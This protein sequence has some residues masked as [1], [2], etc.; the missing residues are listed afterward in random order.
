[1]WQC[2]WKPE[3]VVLV[4]RF[5]DC[6]CRQQG[7]WPELLQSLLSA[8]ISPGETGITDGQALL[9]SV[10]L[11][12]CFCFVFFR[13]RV[14]LY[15]PGC[16]GTHSVDQ[17]G[18]K[19]R[20]PPAS[21]SRVLG[22]KAFTTTPGFAFSFICVLGIQTQAFM[23]VWQGRYPMSHFPSKCSPQHSVTLQ[24]I[25]E[26]FF[27]KKKTFIFNYVYLQA[28]VYEGMC[29]CV[30]VCEQPEEGVRS[31][32]SGII[33]GYMLGIRSNSQFGFQN[34]TGIYMSRC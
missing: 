12:V 31:P 2:V 26:I 28:L 9:P 6:H 1:M 25:H 21:A 8:P 7:S 17:A 4:R 5:S 34:H 11:F 16:P 24:K 14:S 19:L 23:L 29:V 3:G 22:L 33:D 27:R 10:F 30:C 15:S 13:D 32:R 20:N 18:L